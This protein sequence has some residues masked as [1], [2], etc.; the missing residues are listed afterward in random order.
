MTFNKVSKGS[1]SF[2]K[3]EAT[4]PGEGWFKSGWFTD[5]WLTGDTF[6]KVEKGESNYTEI[7]KE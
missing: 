3:V 5:H 7:E 4:K 6:N 2:N 1:S